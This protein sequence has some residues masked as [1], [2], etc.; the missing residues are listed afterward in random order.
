MVCHFLG[1]PILEKCRSGREAPKVMSWGC[2]KNNNSEE[3]RP[4]GSNAGDADK[5][6]PGAGKIVWKVIKKIS[7]G[8]ELLSYQRNLSESCSTLISQVNFNYFVAESNLRSWGR[9]SHNQVPWWMSYL[10]CVIE[11][12]WRLW[13]RRSGHPS[14]VGL[15]HESQMAGLEH[16]LHSFA[17][18]S[19][20]TKARG[21]EMWD[22]KTT[23]PNGMSFPEL[24]WSSKVTVD[25]KW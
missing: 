20:G 14:L 12:G 7:T 16:W 18:T 23:S 17:W 11:G 25:L 1:W 22:T 4:G 6:I 21:R 9:S 13:E 8:N 15:G 2:K 24:S 10:R 3:L 19:P 5:C